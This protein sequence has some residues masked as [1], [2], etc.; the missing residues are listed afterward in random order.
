MKRLQ[1]FFHRAASFLPPSEVIGITCIV[2]LSLFLRV[3]RIPSA[4]FSSDESLYSYASYAISQGVIPYR[5]IQL[6]HPPLM[7]LI[8]AMFI[9]L[10]GTNLI[11]LRLWTVGINLTNVFLVY[12]MV[13]FV[14]RNQKWS[15]KLGL[16]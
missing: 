3:T 12:L 10:S 1:D 11:Y 4:P 15:V 13:K 16:L 9:R 14:L 5:E 7:Y 2:V 8:N 6:A